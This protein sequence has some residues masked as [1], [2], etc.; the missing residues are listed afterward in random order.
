MTG[1]LVAQGA[2]TGMAGSGGADVRYWQEPI[3][4]GRLTVIDGA[5]LGSLLE[6]CEF[7]TVPPKD[8]RGVLASSTRTW[9][10]ARE[11]RQAGGGDVKRETLLRGGRPWASRLAAVVVI[12]SSTAAFAG[13]VDASLQPSSIH[14]LAQA[15]PSPDE[16]FDAAGCTKDTDCKGE[17]ICVRSS[18]VD[19]ERPAAAPA[20]R[21]GPRAADR[22]EIEAERRAERQRARRIAISREIRA[23]ED[24][25]PTMA[26]P[27]VGTVLGG[28]MLVVGVPMIFF[29]SWLIGLVVA[30]VGVAVLSAGL[31]GYASDSARSRE[32]DSSIRALEEERRSL[33][34]QAVGAPLP[35][36]VVARY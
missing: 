1:T 12:L 10:L 6:S 19:P 28:L 5:S 20:P 35:G 33:A 15:G 27:I 25:R 31:A 18:C 16:A 36:F 7:S 11:S 23:L 30:V 29:V 13:W 4:L 8:G 21:A 22:V 14:L 32:I 2:S 26:T 9:Y 24:S 17:R 3:N 34:T